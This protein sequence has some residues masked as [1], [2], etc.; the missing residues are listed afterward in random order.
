MSSA[1]S[2]KTKQ[3]QPLLAKAIVLIVIVILGVFSHKK[4]QESRS[5]IQQEQQSKIVLQQTAILDQDDVINTN[6]LRTL[7]PLVKNVEG[8][9]VWSSILQQGV[10][11]FIGLPEIENDQ[12]YQLWVYDLLGK[13]SKP[14]LSSQFKEVSSD[15]FLVPFI[16]KELINNPFK[17]E[18]LLATDGEKVRQ[19]LL[20][21]QP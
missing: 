14:I 18:L 16:A 15:K 1:V 21:A 19:P 3:S 10:L 17:F 20:L 12:T 5:E 2:S 8:S 11:E 13:D 7:N 9:V 6:W 4:L